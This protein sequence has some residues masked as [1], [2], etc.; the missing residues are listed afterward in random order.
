MK[1]L[2]KE[3]FSLNYLN[4]EMLNGNLKI[5]LKDYEI[6]IGKDDSNN[7]NI[8]IFNKDNVNDFIYILFDDNINLLDIE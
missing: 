6:F 3:N 2:I 1:N 4:D 7:I 8:N 5:K